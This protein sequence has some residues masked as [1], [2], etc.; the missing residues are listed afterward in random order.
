MPKAIRTLKKRDL[1]LTLML[2]PTLII[3]FIYRIAPSVVLVI[4][5][6]ELDAR[7]GIWGSDWVGL[8]N[9]EMLFSRQFGRILFNTISYNIVFV[10]LITVLSLLI[11][12]ALRQIKSQKLVSF[13]LTL[14]MIP[15]LLSWIM[16][17]YISRTFLDFNGLVNSLFITLG[18]EPVNWFITIEPWRFIIVFAYLWRNVGFFVL[19][20]Y[21]AMASIKKEY[22]YASAVDG[23]SRLSQFYR[24]YI[25]LIGKTISV[26]LLFAM[27][28]ILTSDVG[29]FFN[30][31][32]DSGML[33]PVTD[34]I[35][36]FMFRTLRAGDFEISVAANF[37]QSIGG[38]LMVLLVLVFY[39]RAMKRHE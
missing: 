2:L 6:K 30:L 7:R 5:F 20:Y 33:Y 16:V 29:L 3:I 15:S 13:L 4:A 18:R 35:D 34:V 28:D 8:R 21:S 10:A 39:W 14:F 37:I 22:I 11:A 12:Y 19:I 32:R 27:A 31:T 24:V 26:I 9:F 23:A 38:L 1:L 36:T 17:T 25:P